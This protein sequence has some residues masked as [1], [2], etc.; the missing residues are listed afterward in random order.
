MS[1]RKEL[2]T[3]EEKCETCRFWKQQDEDQ[4]YGE[5]RRSTP[6]INWIGCMAVI[7]NARDKVRDENQYDEE[8]GMPYEYIEGAGDAVTEAT[9]GSGEAVW[10]RTESIEWCGEYQPKPFAPTQPVV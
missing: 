2:A 9:F 1:E 10:P 6:Q 7:L 8:Y 5:C 3:V 4:A